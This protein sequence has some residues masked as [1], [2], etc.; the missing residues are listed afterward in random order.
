MYIQNVHIYKEIDI[1][2]LNDFITHEH[3]FAFGLENI[4]SRAL[5]TLAEYDHNNSINRKHPNSGLSLNT[6]L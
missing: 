3:K 2:F 1:P 4:G 6:L 5:N